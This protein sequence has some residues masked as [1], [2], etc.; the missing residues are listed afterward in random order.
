MAKQLG[1]Y[2]DSSICVNC[3]VCQV[4]CQDK[5]DL[6][7]H[8][9]WRRVLQYGGGDWLPHPSR[10]GLFIPNQVFS[11]AV[12]ISCNHCEKPAC[13]EVC[14][15]GAMTKRSDGIV[16]VD[17][18]NCIGCRYCEW[19]CPY[20]APQYNDIEGVMSKCNF[21]MDLIDKGEKPACVSACVMRAL[22]FG[23]IEELRA[24]YGN[25]AAIEP[26][27]DASITSPALV[28]TPHRHAQASGSGTGRVL[29]LPEEL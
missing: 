16:F 18:N 26:L 12:S 9:R 11:Y 29:N 13:V 20:S 19:A 8:L 22:D 5:N 14:P 24:R 3:K 10:P 25:L 21:C 15:T 28:I 23:D 1:F 4:A 7:P 2:F 17:Q 27:P 6:P